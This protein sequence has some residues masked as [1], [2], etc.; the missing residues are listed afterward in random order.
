MS[1]TVYFVRHGECVANTKG[2]IAGLG[3][4]SP[5]TELGR[6]QA[7]ETA[8]NLKGINFDLVISSPMSRTVET[9]KI[10]ANELGLTNEIITKSEF[11]EKDVGEFTGKPKEEYFAFETSGGEAGETTTDMQNR[12]KQGLDWLELQSFENA[13]VVTHNGTVRMIRTVLENL[14]AKDFAKIQQLG[15]GEYYKVELI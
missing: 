3:D 15:N 1:K 14:P 7:K 12:V 2:V 4:D 9:T 10:I 13:L 11:S 5:L 6:S 8:Q